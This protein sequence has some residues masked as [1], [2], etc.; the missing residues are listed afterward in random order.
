MD[1]TPERKLWRGILEL[2]GGLALVATL[3]LSL[4]GVRVARASD[5]TIGVLEPEAIGP[6]S[7][8]PALAARFGGIRAPACSAPPAAA[9]LPDEAVAETLERILGQAAERLRAELTPRDG[10]SEHVVLNGQGYNYPRT[11]RPG[12]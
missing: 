7:I 9:A 10:E 6:S 5:P 4:P 12:S 8:D 1:A 3:A 11:E 2:A